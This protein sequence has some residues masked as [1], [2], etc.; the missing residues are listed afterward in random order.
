MNLNKTAFKSI[1]S[2]VI[3]LKL[4]LLSIT[5]SYSQTHTSHNNGYWTTNTNWIGGVAPAL[6]APGGIT[7]NNSHHIAINSTITLNSGLSVNGGTFIHVLD[8]ATLIINGNVTFQNNSN[9]YVSSGAILIINGNVT[10]NNNSDNIII[11]GVI[12]IDGNFTGG[13]GSALAGNGEMEISGTVTTSGSGNVF[14]STVNC[15]SDCNNTAASPLPIELGTFEVTH[16]NGENLVE[17]FTFTERNNN[18][19]TILHSI[20]GINW[21]VISELPGAGNSS[22]INN[23]SFTHNI[24]IGGIHYYKLSQ[25]DYDGTNV[26]FDPV[27]IDLGNL[28]VLIHSVNLSG[29]KVNDTYSGF[30]IDYYSDGSTVKRI[31]Y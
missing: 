9:L 28:P 4:V 19:F 12:S 15:T 7:T 10:N 20:D 24:T 21:E 18:F 27:S 6:G 13:N 29:Q 22:S 16:L 23:Y 17:W 5:I 25:T 14:G 11:D 3:L 1:V 8:G 31:N 2:K 30:V 26:V